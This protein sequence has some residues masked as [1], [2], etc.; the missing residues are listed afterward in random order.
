ML[1]N[2]MFK[3]VLTIK[4]NMIVTEWRINNSYTILRYINEGWLFL[5]NLV[6]ADLIK[7]DCEISIFYLCKS[8]SNMFLEPTSTKQLGYVSCSG[9]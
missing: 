8:R 4:K 5:A 3:Y 9:K 7:S 6:Y 2:D 1:I